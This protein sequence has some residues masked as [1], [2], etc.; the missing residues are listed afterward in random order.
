MVDLPIFTQKNTCF[1]MGN[2]FVFINGG[3]GGGG[4]CV[5]VCVCVWGGGGG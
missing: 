2:S 1:L 3:V 4:V 5:C